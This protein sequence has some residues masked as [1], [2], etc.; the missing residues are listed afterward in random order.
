MSLT[1]QEASKW[2]Q[3][4]VYLTGPKHIA[5]NWGIEVRNKRK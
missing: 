4:L 3:R 2:E 1:I 5:V